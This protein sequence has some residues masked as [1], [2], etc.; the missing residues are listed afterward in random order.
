M[1][2]LQ[3]SEGRESYK[4]VGVRRVRVERVTKVWE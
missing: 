1:R 4:G 3:R 2:E